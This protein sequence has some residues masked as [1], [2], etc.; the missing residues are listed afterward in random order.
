M[1]CTAPPLTSLPNSPRLYSMQCCPGVL[2]ML[3]RD[4]TPHAPPLSFDPN[5][6][7]ST[8]TTLFT[9]AAKSAHFLADCEEK[10]K[11]PEH[12]VPRMDSIPIPRPRTTGKQPGSK[13]APSATRALPALHFVI[14]L[15]APQTLPNKLNIYYRE[16]FRLQGVLGN[17]V[18]TLLTRRPPA[19]MEGG[20]L[21]ST[22]AN[23][24]SASG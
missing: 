20:G 18:L 1:T 4:H 3:P 10:R 8:T 16:L 17:I 19:G 24:Q 6:I 5:P 12:H 9:R 7:F 15:P 23:H 13:V 21:A 2:E 11:A 22:S 14:S